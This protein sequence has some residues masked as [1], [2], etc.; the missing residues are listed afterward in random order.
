MAAAVILDSSTLA[1]S[2]LVASV[3]DSKQLT[4]SRRVALYDLIASEAMAWA[5]VAIS[6]QEVDDRGIQR[7][8]LTALRQAVACLE[9]QPDY[10]LFD[11]YAVPGVP[12][13]SLGVWK[14]DQ[15]SPTVAAASILAK[16][17]RDREM[18]V[19]EQQ[20][21]GYGFAK[22]KGYLTAEHRKAIKKLGV[23]EIHRASFT[24][25]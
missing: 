23:S 13:P 24:L 20:F 4:E 17:T 9:I 5:V 8:N 14:G 11:G 16:V 18:T 19:A 6:S 7:A 22:H 21:P 12:V 1:T 25:G 15:V 2:E 10:A 3:A